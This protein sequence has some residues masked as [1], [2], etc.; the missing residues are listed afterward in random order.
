MSILYILIKF[1]YRL[2]HKFHQLPHF[3]EVVHIPGKIQRTYYAQ[4]WPS[5]VM[6]NAVRKLTQLIISRLKLFIFGNQQ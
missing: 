5:Y 3:C 6:S 1:L 4:Q 2:S